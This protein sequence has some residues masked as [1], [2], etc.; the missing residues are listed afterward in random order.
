[1]TKYTA[2]RPPQP[3]EIR[4]PLIVVWFS[5]RSEASM[6]SLPTPWTRSKTKCAASEAGNVYL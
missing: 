2:R 6:G 4:K 3:L 5:T 1:M